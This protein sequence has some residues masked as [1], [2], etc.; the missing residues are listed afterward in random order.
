MVTR[1]WCLASQVVFRVSG[2]SLGF[3]AE[4]FGRLEVCLVLRFSCWFRV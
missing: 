4:P 3:Q 1:I 2:C